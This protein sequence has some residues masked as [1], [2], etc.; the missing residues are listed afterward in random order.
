MTEKSMFYVGQPVLYE[1]ELWEFRRIEKR[2]YPT[3]ARILK[4]E[5]LESGGLKFT[6]RVVL[7]SDLIFDTI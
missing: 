7:L 3:K 6:G 2:Y 1:G 4:E 5:R